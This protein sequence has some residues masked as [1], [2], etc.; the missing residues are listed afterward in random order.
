MDRLHINEQEKVCQLALSLIKGVGFTIWKK[1]IERLGSAMH[2][3]D[4]SP[5]A[6]KYTLKGIPLPIIQAI[7]EKN[8]LKTAEKII[9]EHA[10]RKIN[11]ISFFEVSYPERLKHIGKSP[12]FLY[13]QGNIAFDAPKIVSIVGTRN[14]TVY[15]KKVVENLVSSLSEYN[16]VIVSGLAYGVDIHAHKAAL[17]HGLPTLG[18]LASGLDKIY[19][20]VHTKTA[21]EMLAN[22]GLITEFPIGS[23]L[24]TF[25]FPNRNRIIA[26]LADA[27]IVVEADRK[28]GAIITANFANAYNREVFAV[29][30]NIYDTFSTGCNYLIKTQ[31]AH[32][33]TN[34]DDIAYIMNWNKKS[35]SKP[36]VHI[37]MRK[38]A[39]LTR[40]EQGAVYA[41]NLS[42]KEMHIDELTQHTQLSSSHLSNILLQLELKNIVE[43]LPGNKFKLSSL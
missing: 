1:L 6:I 10:Q 4:A 21:L 20:E 25:Q 18:V 22:G 42:Q 12:S 39:E 32:L 37:N 15:G 41:L 33:L 27:T 2:L 19:P 16:V 34:I 13:Y 30:G 38:L 7:L 23:V 31:Q 36:A 24:E 43:F 17:A 11:V 14:A 9:E 5:S 26:G 40:E 3:F 35:E 28:S 8:T 29:P